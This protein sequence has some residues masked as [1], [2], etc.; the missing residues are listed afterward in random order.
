[1]SFLGLDKLAGYV[2]Q[3]AR[4][5]DETLKN[6]DALFYTRFLTP[7]FSASDNFMA[8]SGGNKYVAADIVSYDSSTPLK[9]R[10]SISA[11]SGKIPKRAIKRALNESEIMQYKDLRSRGVNE[12]KLAGFIFKDTPFVVNGIERSVEYDFLSLLCG[13]AVL[14]HDETNTKA[15]EGIRI[16]SKGEVVKGSYIKSVWDKAIDKADEK[17]GASVAVMSKGTFNKWKASKFALDLHSQFIGVKTEVE[18]TR[19]QFL[20]EIKSEYGI[21][22]V[23]IDSKIKVESNGKRTTVQPFIDDVVTF[24]PSMNIGRAV[25]TETAE[26]SQEF[27]ND[28]C[29]AYAEP[30]QYTLVAVEHK[31]EPLRLETRAQAI[32]LPVFD[33]ID[34]MIFLELNK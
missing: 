4:L 18:P 25:Y 28:N 10:D 2:V 9:K 24:L 5:T 13:E 22:I 23:I 16:R 7:D 8:V 20:D 29:V 27:R 30:N 32:I 12:Q 19:Q 33:E 21:E 6:N 26:H 11:Y 1:M 17:D 31:T 15:G 34:N 3:G 14:I